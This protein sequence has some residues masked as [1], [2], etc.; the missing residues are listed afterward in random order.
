MKINFGVVMWVALG[1]FL[2]MCLTVPGFI[3]EAFNWVRNLVVDIF[4]GPGQ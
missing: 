2:A 1:I 3:N 4:N